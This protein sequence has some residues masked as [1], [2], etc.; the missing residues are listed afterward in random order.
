M[1]ALVFGASGFI[2]R[3]LVLELAARG[4][5]VIAAVRS[6]QSRVRTADWLDEHDVRADAVSFVHVDLAIEALGFVSAGA[7]RA[8]EAAGIR[9]VFNV[10]GAYAFG[11]SMEHAF[12]ANVEVSRRIVEYAA[13]LPEL[14]RLVHLSGYRVGGQSPDAAPWTPEQRRREYGRLGAYE[15]S[16][17][18]SDAVVQSAARRL[19]VPYSIANPS[20]VI[21]HSVTGEAEQ[22]IGLAATVQDLL[23]GRLPAIPGGSDTFVPVVTVDHLARV[24]A[25]LPESADAAGRS[26]WILDDRTPPLPALL[27]LIADHAG[28]SAPRLRI[29]AWLI[30]RLPQAITRADP[31]TLSFLSSD[32]YPTGAAD[33]L[34]ARYGIEQPDVRAALL[35]WTDYLAGVGSVE[36]Q[37]PSGGLVSRLTR[38]R[39]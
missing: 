21:G 18:E 28:V 14:R 13:A 9:D 5:T 10:S 32:R 12:E 27:R 31:E 3:W 22:Y 2:G 4:R 38:S 34:A 6:E 11:M 35:R 29:P 15:A 7:A 17:I 26:Y 24:M 36:S 39:R 8:P 33:E 1:S 16:K 37:E 19:G 25:V 30:A 23:A 20:T